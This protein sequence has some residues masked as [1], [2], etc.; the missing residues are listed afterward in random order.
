MLSISSMTLESIK[1]AFTFCWTREVSGTEKLREQT[2]Q[3]FA[4]SGQPC[5]DC[6]VEF[7]YGNDSQRAL[8]KNNQMLKQNRVS[9]MLI[10][11]EQVE[12]VLSSFGGDDSRPQ[13]NRPNRNE[14]APPGDFGR[15]GCVVMIS[16]LCYKA[17]IDDLLAEF[18]EFDLHPDQVIRRFNELG[19]PTGNACINF[20]SSQ[21]AEAACEKHNSAKILNRSIWMK[22]V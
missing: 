11:R 22:R 18:R 3:R 9:V 4:S 13:S 17:T 19:Q 15:P 21:D 20:N 5:G 1:C 2:F 10:P 7:K 12:A 8:S 6:F 14:W 16:N